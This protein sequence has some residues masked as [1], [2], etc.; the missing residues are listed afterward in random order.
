MNASE[1]RLV[2]GRLKFGQS[3]NSAPF[4][5][6]IVIFGTPRYPKVVMMEGI[7]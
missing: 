4:P 6:A 5:S 3:K 2:P 1:I 7:Q